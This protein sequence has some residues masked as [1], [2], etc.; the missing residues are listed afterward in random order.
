MLPRTVDRRRF[1]V[2][3]A[4]AAAGLAV[5]AHAAA[6]PARP[7]FSPLTVIAGKPRERGR[8]YGKKFQTQI[9]AFLDRELYRA[10][11]GKPNPKAAMLRYADACGKAV[12]GWSGE[13]HDEMEGLAEGAGLKLEE[14]VLM[15]LHEELSRKGVLPKVDHCTAV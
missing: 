14:V 13:I 9:A 7:P 12:K 11:T 6:P 10:F 15:S 8:A 2:G 4:A 5:R 3:A 1:L